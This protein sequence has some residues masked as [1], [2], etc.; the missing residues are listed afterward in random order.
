MTHE[1]R[2]KIIK[3][4]IDRCLTL[5]RTRALGYATD[6]DALHNFR[7]AAKLQGCTMAQALDGMMAKH[8]VS[9]YDMV[10]S[11]KEYDLKIWDEKICDNINYLLLLK[12]VVFEEQGLHDDEYSTTQPWKVEELD[13]SQKEEVKAMYEFMGLE[14]NL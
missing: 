1:E 9:I 14:L 13:E 8:T 10:R 12:A 6:D 4:T 7:N 2:D 11:G 3:E 5:L